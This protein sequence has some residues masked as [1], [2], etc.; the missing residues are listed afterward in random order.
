MS[1]LIYYCK[2]P[3]SERKAREMKKHFKDLFWL[4]DLEYIAVVRSKSD[5]DKSL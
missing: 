4:Y 2:K 5:E 3:L 1:Q